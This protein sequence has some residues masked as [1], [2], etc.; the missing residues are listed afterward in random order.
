MVNETVILS[1]EE[2]LEEL[3]RFFVRIEGLLDEMAAVSPHN[4]R[5]AVVGIQRRGDLL[6][7]RLLTR[8]AQSRQ[9]DLPLGTLDIALYRDDFSPDK[10]Q[11][12]VRPS[13]I[14]FEVEG[15]DILLVDDVFQTGRTIRAAL[16]L[17]A[18]FGRAR[19]V[20][21]AVFVDRG[22]RE[23]P[24]CPD[25]VGMTVDNPIAERVQL[26]LKELDGVDLIVAQTPEARE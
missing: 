19:R 8:L 17:L 12:T 2:T 3:D 24:I 9:L 11:P 16:N 6:G 22:L 1:S 26:R 21:L 25:V 18:D 23:L 4:F 5:P 20:K 7:A 10:Q 13:R 15:A 14:P